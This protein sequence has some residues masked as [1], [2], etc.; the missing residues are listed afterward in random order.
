M[1]NGFLLLISIIFLYF[2][3]KFTLIENAFLA[4]SPHRLQKMKD[5]EHENI[6]FIQ[7]LVKDR[8]LYSTTLIGDYLSNA[9]CSIFCSLFFYQLYSYPG[10]VI[11]AFLSIL[12]VIIL[13]ETYPRAMGSQN[14]EKIVSKNISFIRLFLN[15]YRPLSLFIQFLSSLIVNITGGDQNYKE[16][17]ITEDELKDAV[18]LGI[19]EGIIDQNESF[20]IENV[21]DF[22]DS[23]AKDIMTPRT[24]IVAIN[25]ESTYDEILQIVSLENYSRMPVYE[26][27]IDNIV[28]ILNVKDLFSMDRNR[29]LKDNAS[30]I[31]K[32]FF[33]F[34]FKPTAMLFDEMRHKKL[35]V[36]IVK[37][38]Y[39]GTEGL[40]TME[41]LIERIV[42]NISDEYDLE[43]DENI[44]QIKK[45]EYLIDG[46]V[47]LDE[48]NQSLH[49]DLKSDE[50]ESV[51]GLIIEQIDRIPKKGE[52]FTIDNLQFTIRESSE[53][54]IE[55]IYLKI[56]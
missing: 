56:K 55:K 45:N 53:K 47:K 19:E 26:D 44:I 20:M 28:G 16:P 15:L 4:L 42:G 17:L 29:L 9:F 36:A 46:S 12:F 49:L 39:G 51:A 10:I 30:L 5:S 6:E 13:G 33:T 38:E 27:N 50:F 18:S 24:D 23:Y 37:D 31:K 41:D 1:E 54:R 32:P 21:I 43:D 3:Y 14:Y 52:S 11:G 7:S 35:T 48:L 25:I 34:E 40:I 2:S 22:R 8:N